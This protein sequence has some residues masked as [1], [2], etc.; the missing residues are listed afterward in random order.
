MPKAK[1]PAH[2]SAERRGGMR[3][4]GATL[5]A[6]AR[7]AIG[8]RGFAEGGL[9]T[10]WP[11]IV[12]AEIAER[13]LPLKLVFSPGSTRGPGA[14]REGV[15]HVRIAGPLALELQHLEPIVLQRINGYFGYSAV[16][17]LRIIQ[18]PLPP[19]R[20]P[21]PPPRPRLPPEAEAEL[22][23]RLEHIEDAAVRDALHRYGRAL[24]AKPER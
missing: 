22:A 8:R 19:I 3:S 12:G 4:L 16:A 7:V 11:A 17:R 5:P 13:S 20:R 21:A 24:R 1:T 10:D 6:V 23:K 2:D 15:L 18:G 14:R 9:L